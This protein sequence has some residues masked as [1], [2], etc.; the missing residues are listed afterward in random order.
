MAENLELKLKLQSHQPVLKI[1]KDLKAD[2]KGLLIQKDIYYKTEKGLLKLRIEVN[3]HTLIFYLRDEKSKD[4]F[5][6]FEILNVEGSNAEGFFGKI[7]NL[8]AIVEK[9]R[10]LFMFDNTRIHLDTVKNLGKFIEL[11]TLVLA[12]KKDA[13]KRFDRLVKILNLPLDNQ[14]KCSYRDL[15]LNKKK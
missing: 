6:D 1:L 7:F 3:K 5:S 4:R 10:K 9:N 12:G 13:K 8:E 11:E 15:I 2:Y 14:I